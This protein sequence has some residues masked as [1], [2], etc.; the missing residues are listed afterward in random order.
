MI[1]SCAFD[2]TAKK[3]TLSWSVSTFGYDHVLQLWGPTIPAAAKPRPSL[4]TP[5]PPAV[6]TSVDWTGPPFIASVPRRTYN[7]S[8]I[9]NTLSHTHTAWQATHETL[10]TGVF[11][12]LQ[13]KTSNST[14][15]QQKQTNRGC[16]IDKVKNK[17]WIIW[18]PVHSRMETCPQ[19]RKDCCRPPRRP[20]H[21]SFISV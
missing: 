9:T 19:Q 20:L 21:T 17:V 16:F 2:I 3:A 7:G 8:L 10:K 13:A 1:S 18:L 15:Q 5:I 11:L 14:K 12:G 6:P 4:V